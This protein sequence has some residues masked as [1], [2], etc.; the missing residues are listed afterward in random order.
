MT[1]YETRAFRIE[2]WDADP[3][4]WLVLAAYSLQMTDYAP[5]WLF[6]AG[7]DG[8]LYQRWADLPDELTT[9]AR[10]GV[11]VPTPGGV[12]ARFYVRAPALFEDLRRMKIGLNRAELQPR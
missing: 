5:Y 1:G 6:V 10:V 9:Q 11:E 8:R 4:P 12:E 3:K 2:S 7:P